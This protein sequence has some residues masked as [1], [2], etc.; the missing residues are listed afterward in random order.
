M[1]EPRSSTTDQAADDGSW[2]TTTVG[3]SGYRVALTARTHEFF[4]DEPVQ[5]GGTDAGPTPYEYLLGA[6][7]SCMAMTLRMYADRKGWPLDSVE[8]RLRSA[9]AHEPDCERCA[10]SDVGITAVE[11]TVAL[12]GALTEEQRTRLMEIAERCPVNQTLARGI[13]VRSVS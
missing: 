10:T 7:S 11:R 1:T 5:L 12:G 4:A 3:A 6:L 8:I 9:R 13:V 2:V